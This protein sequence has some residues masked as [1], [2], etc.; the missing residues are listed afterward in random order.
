VLLPP[1]LALHL[2]LVLHE[3]GTNAS[4]Y[5]A[6]SRPE[7]RV[8]LSWTVE[9]GRLHLNWAEQGGPPVQVPQRRGF[10]T[11]LIER[12]VKAEGGSARASY[13]AEGMVWDITLVLPRRAPQIPEASAAAETGART[14]PQRS[15]AAPA[16]KRLA[17]QRLLVVEDEPLV[18]MELSTILEDAGAEVIG[19]AGTAD[20]ALH[21]IETTKLD[22]ALLDGNLGGQSVEAIAAA[23]TRCN[24]PF[25]F[26]TGYGKEHLPCAFARTGVLPKPFTRT[27]LLE[28]AAQLT[29][30]KGEVVPLRK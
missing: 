1:Q 4:K 6:L 18:V 10:G 29:K 13:R 7:G 2:A 5:G 21:L 25:V 16:Q 3:L 20:Q 23:L 14:L 26:V 19:P 9:D 30:P 22:G 12:S 15:D 27:E 8:T 11:T 28:A 24:V 17:Q